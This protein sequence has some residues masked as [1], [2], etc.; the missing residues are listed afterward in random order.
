MLGCLKDMS[1]AAQGLREPD[2][3]RE[4]QHQALPT[5]VKALNPQQAQLDH[6]VQDRRHL[7]RPG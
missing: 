4:H 2:P 5:A 6:P 1:P 7:A 3:G